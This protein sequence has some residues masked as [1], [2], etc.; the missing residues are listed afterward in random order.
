MHACAVSP[1]WA[2]VDV[3]GATPTRPPGALFGRH[4]PLQ[5]RFLPDAGQTAN[6]MFVDV[7]IAVPISAVDTAAV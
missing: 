1:K 2:G 3:P 6:D 5:P 4:P 7:M